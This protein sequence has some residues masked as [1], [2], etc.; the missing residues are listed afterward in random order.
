LEGGWLTVS[1]LV[2]Y[3]HNRKHGSLQADMV[4]EKELRV[5]HLDL[6]ATRRDYFPGSQEEGLKAYPTVTHFL[7]Q[8]NTYFK[9]P[10]STTPRAKHIQTTTICINVKYFSRHKSI[11]C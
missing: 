4:L 7:Q 9:I 6:K 2:H 5:M 10:H 11:L 3:Y 8:G 1:G